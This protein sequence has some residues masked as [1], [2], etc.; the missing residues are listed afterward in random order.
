M[1]RYCIA[2]QCN[3]TDYVPA[4]GVK[5]VKVTGESSAKT[6]KPDAKFAASCA[7]AAGALIPT[8]AG[9]T[10]AMMMTFSKG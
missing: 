6:G 1:L 2:L 9:M 5:S 4:P 3:G 7:T 8:A 10:R